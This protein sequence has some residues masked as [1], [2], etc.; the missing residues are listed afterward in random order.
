MI[1][2][3]LFAGLQESIGQSQITYP[4]APIKVREL[5]ENLS[6]KYGEPRFKG[7]M[8]AVNGKVA[9]Q[10]DLINRGNVVALLP[11]IGGG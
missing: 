10:E 5:I 9:S 8:V 1:N 7:A 2:V 11:P 3:L 6:I 4:H